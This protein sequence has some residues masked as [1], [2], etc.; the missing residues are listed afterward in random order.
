MMSINTT[1]S[2]YTN[3]NNKN[4]TKL[5]NNYYLLSSKSVSLSLTSSHNHIKIIQP[6]R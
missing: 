6:L 5:I 1:V 4:K 3:N 2:S